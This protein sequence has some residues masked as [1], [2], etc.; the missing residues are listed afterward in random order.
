[1]SLWGASID[2]SKA[3]PWDFPQDSIEAHEKLPGAPDT[4][5]IKLPPSPT[6][7]AQLKKPTDHLPA[8]HGDAEGES[9]ID[10][11]NHDGSAPVTVQPEADTA[12]SQ[13]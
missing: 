11:T 4:T 3:V 8:D 5:I 10:F 2:A 1:M 6:S 7:A 12:T 13:D 9:H